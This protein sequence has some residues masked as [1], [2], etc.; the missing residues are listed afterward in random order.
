MRRAD[1][2]RHAETRGASVWARNKLPF[3]A[4]NSSPSSGRRKE[5]RHLAAALLLQ[6]PANLNAEELKLSDADAPGVAF[7][8]RSLARDQKLQV[9]D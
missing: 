4:P 8:F 6:D 1:F 3:D 9:I 7:D 5:A 2:S